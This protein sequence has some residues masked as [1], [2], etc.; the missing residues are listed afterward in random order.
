MVK[1][2]GNRTDFPALCL[3]AYTKTGVWH[4]LDVGEVLTRGDDDDHRRT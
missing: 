2:G 4:Y 3:R 1:N